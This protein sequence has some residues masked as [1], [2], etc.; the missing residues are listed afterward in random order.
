MSSPITIGGTISSFVDFS[1]KFTFF[2][3]NI[4]DEIQR[5]HYHGVLYE[6]EELQIIRQYSLGCTVFFDI[7]SNVGNHAIF[8]AKVLG[9]NKI[10]TFEAN[11][12]ASDI[13]KIN[14]SLNNLSD[15]INTSYLGIGVGDRFGLFNINISHP[16]NIGGATLIEKQIPLENSLGQERA[17]ADDIVV[18]PIDSL[19]IPD[20]PDFVKIDVEGME[21]AVLKGMQNIIDNFHPRIFIEVDNNNITA[22]SEWLEKNSYTIISRIRRYPVNENFLIVHSSHI[23][24]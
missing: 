12:V 1:K 24:Q 9:A 14:I 16:N 15:K 11:P 20:N 23:K 10:Y 6:K 8:F 4:H 22:F 13:L 18:L 19:N 17:T 2:I 3:S 5:H 21:I 7:G